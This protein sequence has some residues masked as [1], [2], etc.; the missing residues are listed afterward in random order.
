MESEMGLFYQFETVKQPSMTTQ[1]ALQRVKK[2]F[3]LE[4]HQSTESGL[5]YLTIGGFNPQIVKDPSD[6]IW[7]Q[8]FCTQHWEINIDSITFSD[9]VIDHDL[10]RKGIRARISIEE[11]GIIIRQKHWSKVSQILQYKN[12]DIRCVEG[13]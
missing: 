12:K 6:I 4:M 2:V 11:R 3:S 10:S 7:I 9:T 8:S 13:H 1:V 5:N